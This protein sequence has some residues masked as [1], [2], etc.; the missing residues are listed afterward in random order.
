MSFAEGR[1][2][3]AIEALEIDAAIGIADWEQLRRQR[4]RFDVAVYREQFGTEQSI[5]DCY[6]YS[7]LQAFLVSFKD[8]AQIGLLETI[9]A[10][11]MDYC[12]QDSSIC[13]AEIRLTKPDVFGGIGMP[14][15]SAALT[16]AQWR[17]RK[18]VNEL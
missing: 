7:A 8:R 6:D 1:Q 10:E 11:V 3:I 18:K 4:L 17:A 13:A 12:F 5:E 9:L 2:R 14:T 16:E 15:V